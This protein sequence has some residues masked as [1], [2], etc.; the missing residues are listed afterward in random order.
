MNR[1]S[2]IRAALLALP[3][4]G[5]GWTWLSTDRASREGVEWDVPVQGFD[6]RDLLQGHYVEFQYEWPGLARRDDD[7][8]GPLYGQSLCLEGRAPV[9]TRTV[10]VEPQAELPGRRPC[11]NFID[12]TRAYA[13]GQGGAVGGRLYASQAEALRLQDQL[14]DP[15]LQGVVR[16]RLRPDGVVTPL[17]MT[18]RPRPEQAR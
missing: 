14:R 10:R 3:L 1:S 15:K 6:P 9:V 8:F 12:G 17:K 4:L 16:I 2:A 11:T 13:D 18:F 5:L 7:E